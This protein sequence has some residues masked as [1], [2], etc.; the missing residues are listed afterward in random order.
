MIN[1]TFLNIFVI[2][3]MVL[4]WDLYDKLHGNIQRS[5][6]TDEVEHEE[7]EVV[8][9]VDGDGLFERAVFL[10]KPT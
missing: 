8:P 5:S 4:K 6:F 10:R 9:S 3:E 7:R 1:F 2:P